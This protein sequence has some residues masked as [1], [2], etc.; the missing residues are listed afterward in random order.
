MKDIITHYLSQS[1]FNDLKKRICSVFDFKSS[2]E[3]I[4]FTMSM[5][6]KTVIIINNSIKL[7][8]DEKQI[9]LQH[10]TAHANGISDEEEADLW[11][12]RRLSDRQKDI[13]INKWKMRH[14]HEYNR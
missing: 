10:E 4:A 1:Q 9:V 5:G 7:S 14:G 11:A 2:S 8:D 13:L 12:L 3:E 6:D